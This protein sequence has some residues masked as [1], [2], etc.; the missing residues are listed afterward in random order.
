MSYRNIYEF[1]EHLNF[2]EGYNQ[3]LAGFKTYQQFV[4]EA[5]RSHLI[6]QIIFR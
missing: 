5:L 2:I 4:V 3:V 1:Y 6:K